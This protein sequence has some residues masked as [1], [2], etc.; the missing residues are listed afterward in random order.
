MSAK[1]ALR[2]N[3]RQ[4]TAHVSVFLP[5]S[6]AS[7]F[8]SPFWPPPPNSL[9]LSMKPPPLLL[10]MFSSFRLSVDCWLSLSPLVNFLTKSMV[11]R[12]DGVCN[13]NDSRSFRV[14]SHVGPM[15]NYI[16]QE[17]LKGRRLWNMGRSCDIFIGG[18]LIYWFALRLTK[19]QGSSRND[20]SANHKPRSA[21]V[22]WTFSWTRGRRG[23]VSSI[24]CLSGSRPGRK[25]GVCGDA[26]WRGIDAPSADLPLLIARAGYE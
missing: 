26:M 19:N 6:R 20:D 17:R 5:L 4:V 11:I 2:N 21:A 10:L 7:S 14:W 22:P 25:V 23:R 9:T 12:I 3:E 8:C 1:F 13:Y 24:S 16:L 15:T 18:Y